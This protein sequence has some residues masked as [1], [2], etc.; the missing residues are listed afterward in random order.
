MSKFRSWHLRYHP[1]SHNIISSALKE[2]GKM[3]PI[4]HIIDFERFDNLFKELYLLTKLDLQNNN[5]YSLPNELKD[6]LAAYKITR[7]SDIKKTTIQ[8]IVKINEY[9]HK[10]KRSISEVDTVKAI[11]KICPEFLS[12]KDSRGNLPLHVACGD[13][14]TSSIYVPLLVEAG[15]KHGVGGSYGRGGL[16][17]KGSQN[18]YA[19]GILARQGN[20]EVFKMLEQLSP[21]IFNEN[22]VLKYELVH[23][24]VFQKKT[25]MVTFLSEYNPSVLYRRTSK[26]GCLPIHF[27]QSLGMVSLLL[28]RAIE[29]NPNN[30]TIGGLFAKNDDGKMPIDHILSQ[31]NKDNVWNCISQALSKHK[32]IPILHQVIRN[33]PIYVDKIIENFPHSCYLRDRNGRLPVHVALETGMKWSV[34]LISI[35][36][37]NL[38]HL[39][40]IDPVTGFYP[41]VL[42]ACEPSSDL[43][44]INHLL[45]LHPGHVRG[46]IHKH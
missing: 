30:D 34:S 29:A 31:H 16:L 3:S 10:K 39:S 45:H 24:A 14:E 11:I 21:S 25:D 15:I 9:M 17:V 42:A 13:D 12:V 19:L 35:M 23:M 43:R 26:G 44:T 36:H 32:D 20:I 1:S 41:F 2:L 22:D 28:E 27:S 8:F 46:G 33:A 4:D 18:L 6:V 38:S 5:N 37:A 7:D 40:D